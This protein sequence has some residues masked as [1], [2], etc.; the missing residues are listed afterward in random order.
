MNNLNKLNQI[1]ADVFYRV[2]NDNLIF[3]D[4]SN[5]KLGQIEIILNKENMVLEYSDFKKE[6]DTFSLDSLHDIL[7]QFIDSANILQLNQLIIS[8]FPLDIDT[9]NKTINAILELYPKG[10]TISYESHDSESIYKIQVDFKHPRITHYV[11]QAFLR[12]FSSNEIDWKDKG[13]KRRARI[14]CFDKEKGSVI[15]IGNTKIERENGIKINRIAY[16]EYFYS[17]YLEEF[18]RHTLERIIPPIIEK[19]ISSRS[20]KDISHEEKMGLSQYIILSW[21]RTIEARE[22]LRESYEKGTLETIRLEFGDQII[23]GLDVKL[24][25]NQLRRM[26]ESQILGFLFPE[27]EPSLVYRLIQFEWGLIK[28]RRPN[29]F[30]TSDTP[31]VF[32]NSFIEKQI[33]LKGKKFLIE[34]EKKVREFIESK[35]PD[36]YIKHTSQNKYKRPGSEGIEIYLPLSSHLCLY[37]VDKKPR[38]KPL[39]VKKVN[40][41]V[42]IQSENSIFSQFNKVEFVI[43]IIKKHPESINKIGRRTITQSITLNKL[44]DGKNKIARFKAIKPPT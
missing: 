36:A 20:L 25:E 17:L 23:K 21:A 15:T 16:R 29:F 32:H 12:N 37:L 18:M 6:S 28:A 40:N 7:I 33:K 24:E 43:K 13:K 38:F 35:K 14:F 10:I 5:N 27:E 22:H 41:L 19:I 9:F 2:E 11:Q 39:D 1:T 26:H 8:K 31:V 4:K 30:L 44:S 34:K 3:Y 42:I